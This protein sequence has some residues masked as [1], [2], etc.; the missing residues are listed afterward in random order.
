MIKV[1]WCTCLCRGSK[2]NVMSIVHKVG[3][4]L[5]V[6][7]HLCNHT[8][9]VEQF[10]VR[11]LQQVYQH[12]WQFLVIYVTKQLIFVIR[13]MHCFYYVFRRTR[14]HSRAR[15]CNTTV[16]IVIVTTCKT[17][18]SSLPISV[19]MH[20]CKFLLP[21]QHFI[22]ATFISLYSSLNLVKTKRCTLYF[23]VLLKQQ[24]HRVG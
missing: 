11:S 16:V 14:T 17:T 8:A 23:P 13:P 2:E 10:R 21:W 4:C 9:A 20:V 15:A 19:W 7:P 5:S 24:A 18:K 3:E 12:R 1:A 22:F 6:V